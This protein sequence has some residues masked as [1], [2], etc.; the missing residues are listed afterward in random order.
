MKNDLKIF[1]G[2]FF[3][4]A[5]SRFI[6]HPP[7]FTSLIALSFY[8][9]AI[10]GIRYLPVLLV[11][12]A[13]TDYIIGFHNTMFFTWGSV[14]IISLISK[15]FLNT[16][17][18]RVSG[19]LFGAIIFYIVTNFGVWY[20]GM[21]EPNLEGLTLSYI[22]GLPFFGYSLI[23]TLIFSAIIEAIY[24]TINYKLKIPN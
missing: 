17:L 21:Y 24:R 10:F 15:Y 6:P 11:C 13:I 3:C 16:I 12:F 9:P 18:T 20:G 19:A 5:A 4:L 7:N 14:I 22:M 1:L 8:V 2:I 23:S